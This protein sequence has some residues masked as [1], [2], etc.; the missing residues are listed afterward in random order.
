[1]A[2]LAHNLFLR[3]K[4]VELL[5]KMCEEIYKHKS[6]NV[7]RSSKAIDQSFMTSLKIYLQQSKHRFLDVT[8]T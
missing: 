6:T 2:F 7:S 4:I 8:H 1:M 5:K 3:L